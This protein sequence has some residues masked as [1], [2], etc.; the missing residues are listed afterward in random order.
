MEKAVRRFFAHFILILGRILYEI[1]IEGEE[2][3]PK[4]GPLILV[5]NHSSAS[6]LFGSCVWRKMRPDMHLFVTDAVMS[7]P[8]KARIFLR[9]GGIP[10]YK[11]KGLSIS[12]FLTALRYLKQ[13]EAVG[14]AP[15]GEMS[16][17]GRLQE[18]KTG[19]AWLAL[20]SGAPICPTHVRGVY[21]ILPRWAVYP[22]LSGNIEIRIGKPFFVSTPG[23]KRKV[24]DPLLL[25]CTKRIRDEICALREKR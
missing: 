16:W 11:A 18:F 1:R 5:G 12:S 24:E 23:E 14:L 22:K 19:A 2:N 21:D 20:K 9:M 13:G 10:V 6:D 8:F 25:E 7:S 3:I 15:E 4:K 17:D